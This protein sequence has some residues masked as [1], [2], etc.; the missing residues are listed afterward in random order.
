MPTPDEPYPAANPDAASAAALS[1]FVVHTKPRQE[2]LAR[3]HLL[4]QEFE[5]YLPLFKV[6]KAPRRGRAGGG[7]IATPG[8]AADGPASGQQAL[9]ANEPMFPRYLFLRPSRPTQSL[10]SVRSTQGVSRLVMFGN[11]PAR[12][13]QPLIDGIRQAEAAR[14]RAEL[15]QISPYRPGM[16]V[17]LQDPALGGLQALVQA[18][19]RDRVTLLLE[20]LGRPQLV[21]VDFERISPL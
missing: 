12:I 1:W 17:R 8:G 13:A 9:T 14:A 21:S 11:Q 5:V 20:I 10:S 15:A 16:P 18:V 3:E 19:S 4:R 7:R 2:S 6:F